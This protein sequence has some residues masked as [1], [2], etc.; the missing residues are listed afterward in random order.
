MSES[1]YDDDERIWW[2]ERIKSFLYVRKFAGAL[3]G[4]EIHAEYAASLG[5]PRQ[6]VFTGYDVVD[7]IHFS[8]CADFVRK[9][10]FKVTAM[11]SKIPE[12]PFFIVIGRMIP[13]K[14]IMGLLEAY[15]LYT[16]KTP[17]SP[18]DLAICGDGE[19][20]IALEKAVQRL[21]L[22][23][24]IHFPGFLPYEEVGYW[25]GFAKAFIH[26]ALK[27]QWGLVVNEAC[28]AG[29]PILCSRTV[30]ARY[31]L[32]RER[33]NGFLFDPENIEDMAGCMLKIHQLTPDEQRKMGDESRRIV[34]AFSPSTFASAFTSAVQAVM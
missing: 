1:K 12:R 23:N 14:N 11:N 15:T 9:N 21:E 3:V 17:D 18:W 16:S 30:G 22:Q 6:R 10:G 4:G 8:R 24:V 25:Y 2:K 33:V 28:A 20:K 34:E 5:I 32:V 29:L 13:R 31:D 7:N 26:P 27:E 19:E